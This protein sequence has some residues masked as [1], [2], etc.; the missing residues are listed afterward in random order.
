MNERG[1][2]LLESLIALAVGSVVLLGVG[3]LYVATSRSSAQDSAQTFLQRRGVLIL[4]E[5]A[6]QIRPAT[7]VPPPAAGLC[8]GGDTNSLK[9]TNS[10]GDFC[11]YRANTCSQTI[12]PCSATAD[13][14]QGE[15]CLSNSPQLL[16][17]RP[18]GGT[19]NLLA[20]SPVPLTVSSFVSSLSG[21]VATVT[22]QLQ[23]N[24]QNSMTFTTAFGQ[25]N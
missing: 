17:D 23:D 20:G 11:F 16:E 4:D 3:S 24:R 21:S 9:A 18:G 10:L 5:M 15:I 12:K 1:V 22:F 14:P 8:K 19:E 2:T 6:R 7:A 13:C 25:R